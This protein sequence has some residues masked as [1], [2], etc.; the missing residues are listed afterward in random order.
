MTII[1]GLPHADFFFNR[2]PMTGEAFQRLMGAI[3]PE[4]GLGVVI[5]LPEGPAV[6][7]V[8]GRALISQPLFM[9]VV[10]FMAG[11]A[12]EWCV[13]EGCSD[14]TAFTGSDRMYA[15][16]RK[17]SHVMLESDIRMPATLIVAFFTSLAL[18]ATMRIV[19][20]VAAV[21]VC[22]EFFALSRAAMAFVTSHFLMLVAQG[23]LGLVVIKGCLFPSVGFMAVFT[24]L[25][26][27]VTV[28]VICL[29]AGDAAGLQVLIVK[30]SEMAA[31]TFN[32]E[33]LVS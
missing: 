16:Q 9:L 29:V 30:R 31:I 25:A 1:T 19:Q 4:L 6:R 23:E 24:P 33:M 15:D 17:A 21:T 20:A 27:A 8:A 3:E 11:D 12:V 2:L 14:M 22:L 28:Q 13:F 10:L 32:L 7:V 5:V 18:L 26:I